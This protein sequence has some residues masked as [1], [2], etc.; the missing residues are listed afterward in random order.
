MVT[1]LSNLVDKIFVYLDEEEEEEERKKKMRKTRT[2]LM[3]TAPEDGAVSVNMTM[4][5]SNKKSF[6]NTS[7]QDLNKSRMDLILEKAVALQDKKKG[8][9]LTFFDTLSY[10]L[11]FLFCCYLCKKKRKDG[12]IKGD[13]LLRHCHRAVFQG[14]IFI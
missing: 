10:Y 9:K 4:H 8:F 11:K 7:R 5:E 2:R 1:S 14:K 3:K 13:D 6:P 12:H